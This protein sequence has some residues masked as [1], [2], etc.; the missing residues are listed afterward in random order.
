MSA[1]KRLG[2]FLWRPVIVYPNG[3]FEVRYSVA[4]VA[5]MFSR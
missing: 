4:I 1:L 3:S 5:M 2:A